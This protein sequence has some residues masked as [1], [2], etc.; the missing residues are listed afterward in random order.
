MTF[1]PNQSF[2]YPSM[3]PLMGGM[4]AGGSGNMESILATLRSLYQLR[5]PIPGNQGGFTGSFQKQ[6]EPLN[7]FVPQ[8]NGSYSPYPTPTSAWNHNTIFDSDLTGTDPNR[9]QIGYQ[10]PDDLLNGGSS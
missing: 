2:A 5:N 4:G 6:N 7:S 8:P 3:K 9:S 1:N 10:P